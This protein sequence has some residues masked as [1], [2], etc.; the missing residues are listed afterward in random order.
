[1]NYSSIHHFLSKCF[2]IFVAWVVEKVEEFES[3]QNLSLQ[4]SVMIMQLLFNQHQIMFRKA[5][6]Y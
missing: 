3:M 1:M 4:R 6:V 5:T 2:K